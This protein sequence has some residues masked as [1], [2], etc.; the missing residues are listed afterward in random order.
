MAGPCRVGRLFKRLQLIPTSRKGGGEAGRRGQTQHL[1]KRHSLCH[2]TM[3]RLR[4]TS[5]LHLLLQG[6]HARTVLQR[7]CT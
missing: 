4:L 7:W 2:S 6:K 1:M 5:L 3:L